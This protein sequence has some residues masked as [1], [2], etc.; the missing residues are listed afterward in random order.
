MGKGERM[1]R[2]G[3]E[4]REGKG[5]YTSFFI[6]SSLKIGLDCVDARL[7]SAYLDLPCNPQSRFIVE[8]YDSVKLTS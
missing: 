7:E 3:E 8:N 5:H 4:G 6:I 2:R 1:G